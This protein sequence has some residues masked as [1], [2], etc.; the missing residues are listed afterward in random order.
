MTSIILSMSAA[1]L[2][3]GPK[4]EHIQ[5]LLHGEKRQKVRGRLQA[6][7]LENVEI[8]RR[9]KGKPSFVVAS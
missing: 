9:R 7:S 8:R 5:T 3:P 2:G 4:V 6:R 1:T